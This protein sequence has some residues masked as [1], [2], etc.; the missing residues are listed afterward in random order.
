MST[1]PFPSPEALREALRPIEDPE[2]DLSIVALGLVRDIDTYPETGRTHVR[3]TLTSPFC[4]L[5]PEIV[6]AVE[7]K[8]LEQEGVAHADVEL[9]WE[10]P[11]DPRRDADEDVKALLGLWD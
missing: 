4:P 5:G 7:D 6:K 2:L 11:W 9:V 10:P 3:L 1:A 8:C